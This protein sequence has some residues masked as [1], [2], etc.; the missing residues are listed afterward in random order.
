MITFD[1]V[2]YRYANT[3]HDAVRNISFTVKPG[4]LNIVTGASGCGKTTL[5]RLTNGLAPQVY[6]GTVTGS[7]TVAGKNVSQTP[8]AELAEDIGTLFQDPEEQ[9]FALNVGNEIAFALRSRGVPADAITERVDAAARRVGIESLVKQDIHALSEG[10]KQK[11]GLADILAL[12]PKVLIL[13]EPSANL[14]P[15]ATA[16]LAQTLI[17]LKH[18][19]CAILVVDHRLYWL[20]DAADAVI[21]MQK[22]E[23]R[24][25]GPYSILSDPLLRSRLG[26]RKDVVEDARVTLPRVAVTRGVAPTTADAVFSAEDLDFAYVPEKPIF[27]NVSFAVKPGITALI[28]KNGAGKTTLARILTGL[29]T[30][31]HGRFTLSG[32]DLSG[33]KGALMPHT[34]LV[35]QN[36]DHQLQMR[37]VLEEI[38]SAVA[39]Q[40]TS[41]MRRKG[42]WLARFKKAHLT[43]ADKAFA[44]EIL[45]SLNL[46]HLALRHPQSLSGGEKQRTV[47]ACALAKKPGILIL[48]EP[49]S[50]LDGANMQAIAGLLKKE[51]EKGRA[52]FLITHDLELLACCDR[53]LDMAMLQDQP[54]HS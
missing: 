17:E 24:E 38:E 18:Q 51:A 49:T 11:V 54:V 7:V 26:L 33:D 14:D 48:D 30:P 2:T 29:N 1:N 25:T 28:G 44:R 16:A 27:K 35:L 20:R 45:E 9:F 6:G 13:D 12:G 15:E 40:K 39:A 5:M 41:L 53:A 52:V 21:I 4:E 19:G 47:I 37:T 10:Q 23:I 32:R 50:G 42:G 34:G 46:T 31:Q 22:G 43:E 3:D 36:A 8:V